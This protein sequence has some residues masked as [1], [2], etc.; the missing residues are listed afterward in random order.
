MGSSLDQVPQFA[1]Y[2]MA[3]VGPVSVGLRQCSDQRGLYG[4]S[5]A[6]T[7]SVFWTRYAGYGGGDNC[8]LSQEKL[9]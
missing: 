8:V 3:S 7:V 6:H 1:N 5:P 4:G 2:R 9:G